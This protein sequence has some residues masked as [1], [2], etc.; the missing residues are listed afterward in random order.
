MHSLVISLLLA[1]AATQQAQSKVEIPL[2]G[3]VYGG[4]RLLVR[5]VEPSVSGEDNVSLGALTHWR[6][7]RG[8]DWQIDGNRI[9]FIAADK[10]ASILVEYRS[11]RVVSAQGALA[12]LSGKRLRRAKVPS[13][14]GIGFGPDHVDFGVQVNL[15]KTY[16]QGRSRL[17]KGVLWLT[18]EPVNRGGSGTWDL[19]VEPTEMV[20]IAYGDVQVNDGTLSIHINTPGM[21]SYMHEGRVLRNSC[22][23]RVVFRNVGKAPMTVYPWRLAPDIEGSLDALY[24]EHPLS[25]VGGREQLTIWR[26]GG[27]LPA[28]YRIAP[29]EE[30]DVRVNES[31]LP[32]WSGPKLETIRL[33]Y[34]DGERNYLLTLFHKNWTT[35][36]Y[37][38]K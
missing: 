37:P 9:R 12:S 2:T 5:T 11:G 13:D 38:P 7:P 28:S 24:T 31:C 36:E 10:S 4:V 16:L 26:R 8:L 29:G 17:D 23:Y 22:S 19:P 14:K 25:N 32:L 30:L 3:R 15:L 20:A 35:M 34:V 21:N 18:C 1:T 6:S 27:K 33:R